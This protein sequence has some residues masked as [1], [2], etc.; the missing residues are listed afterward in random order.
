MRGAHPLRIFPSMDRLSEEMPASPLSSA[1]PSAPSGPPPGPAAEYE[2]PLDGPGYGAWKRGRRAWRVVRT[3]GPFVVA[4]LRDRRRWVFFGAPRRMTTEGHRERAGRMVAAIAGLGPTFIKLA[5]VFGARADILPEPYLGQMARLQDAVRPVAF[6]AVDAVLRA[7]YGRAPAEVFEELDAEPIASAS[8]GQVYRGRAAGREVAVKVIRPGVEEL[9]ALDLDVSFRILWVLGIL[10]P[11]HHIRALT[12]VV[13]EFEKH[14][15]EELDLRIEAENTERFR[16]QFADDPRIR[17]PEVL[18]GYARRRVLV[19]EF[20]HGTK[21]DRLEPLFASGAL[22]FERLMRTLTEAYLRMMLV[23]GRLHADPHP[24]N[25]LV[26]GDGTIVFLD[27]GMTVQIDR[28]TRERIFRLSLAA[29]RDDLDAVIGEMYGM[30]MIDPD[31]PRAEIRAAAA[32]IMDILQRSRE[33]GQRRVQEAVAEILEAFY[34]WPLI[35]PE[36][37]VYLMRATALLE[38]IGFRYDPAFNGLDAVR[39]VLDGMKGELLGSMT[40]DSAGSA[41]DLVG[42][43]QQAFR[44]LVDIVRRA[45]R[46]ELRVRVHPRDF[47]ELEETLALTVRRLLLALFAAVVA[48]VSTLVFTTTRDA[49]VLGI[50][51]GAALLLFLFV[52]LLPKHLLRSPFRRSRRVRPRRSRR[53]R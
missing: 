9:V 44:A 21:V 13:S 2:S 45:E 5:Q 30:G 3:L 11:N 32:E 12:T 1:A 15:R 49:W 53:S 23:G 52:L 42:E 25:I 16:H 41:L 24:G 43:A 38:G 20:V 46:E 19:T 22:T 37:V 29:A 27:F 50:G 51:N 26:E 47:H 28:A 8:L 18:A 14:I 36:E 31:V 48:V 34:T 39:P 7:E 17:A 10:F 35:L 40:R 4:F 33:L 6:P